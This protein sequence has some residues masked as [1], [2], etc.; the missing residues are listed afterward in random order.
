MYFI[1][2]VKVIILF[3]LNESYI[4]AFAQ[5]KHFS[6]L[7]RCTLYYGENFIETKRKH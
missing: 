7:E 3:Q 1:F 2:S 4:L 5:W 6:L